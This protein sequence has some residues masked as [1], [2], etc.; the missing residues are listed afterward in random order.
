M[1]KA[2]E[3]HKRN[4]R[5]FQLIVMAAAGIVFL[6]VFA[7]LPM[8]GIALA[9]KDGDK[10]LNIMRPLLL[11]SWSLD[12]FRGLFMDET[13]W[14]VLANTLTINILLLIF[15]F[16]MPI[17]FALLMNEVNVKFLKKGVQT[18]CNIPHFISWVVYGG[19]II[20]LTNP[21]TGVVNP[22]LEVLGLSTAEHPIDL[23]L[24]KY[25][26]PKIIIA[27]ILK[28]IGWGSIIYSAAIAGINPE[29]Y[30]AAVM[31]GAGR[32]RRAWNITVP[33][34]K[35]TIIIF[36][37]LN[38]SN[39]LSNSFEQFYV[40]QTT[41]NLETTRVLATYTYNV[42]FTWRNYSTSTAISLF[43]GLV[44]VVLLLSSNFLAKRL[45]GEGIF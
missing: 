20:S 28:G 19:I 26:Y 8:F 30:E 4:I 17:L 39:L 15:N 40:F 27:S 11:G 12:N 35:P 10:A 16:P 7:Y 9:F 23:N 43:E 1:I 13:F 21:S 38:M 3:R 36:V 31:D 33:M 42:G 32:W 44:S 2:R 14:Q 24:A 29:L 45:T 41:E 5:D 6:A 22:I 37:L 18:L 25:F 34:I